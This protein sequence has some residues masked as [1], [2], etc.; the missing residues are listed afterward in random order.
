MFL[1]KW[2]VRSFFWYNN[3]LNCNIFEM[4]CASFDKN[5]WQQ[6]RNFSNCLFKVISSRRNNI[7]KNSEKKIFWG[8]YFFP[9]FSPLFYWIKESKYASEVI[10][11]NWFRKRR[12][13]CKNIPISYC[14][15]LLASLQA[16]YLL[17][18]FLL[19]E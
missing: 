2:I 17:I 7:V 16:H 1:K 8:G 6:N 10:Y 5:P 15:R 18:G 12:T 4:K 14:V 19:F 3:V 13:K 11:F 9:N